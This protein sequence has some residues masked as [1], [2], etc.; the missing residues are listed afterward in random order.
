M[1]QRFKLDAES[2]AELL[3]VFVLVAAQRTSVCT[4]C[5]RILVVA[6]GPSVVSSWQHKKLSC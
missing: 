4:L 2:E 5:P 6:E 3:D 1:L